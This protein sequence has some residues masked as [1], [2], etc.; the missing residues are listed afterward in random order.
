MYTVSTVAKK[1]KS[2]NAEV[3][4]FARKYNVSKIIIEN[5]ETFIFDKKDYRLFLI[6]KNKRKIRYEDKKQLTFYF[7]NECICVKQKQNKLSLRQLKKEK[8]LIEKISNI[9]K[10]CKENGIDKNILCKKLKID[11]TVL[12]KLLNKN[13]NLPI[14]EDDRIDNKIYWVG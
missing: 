10:S 1:T 9:L 5:K 11:M 7:Y 8:S 14:A 2:K 3:R 4:Y 12:N 6:Y 13:T